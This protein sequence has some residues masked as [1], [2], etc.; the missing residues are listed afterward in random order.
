MS[1]NNI[2][3]CLSRLGNDWVWGREPTENLEVQLGD[4]RFAGKLGDRWRQ[5]WVIQKG[6]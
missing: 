2:F 3:G 5:G 6:M 4:L 1:R